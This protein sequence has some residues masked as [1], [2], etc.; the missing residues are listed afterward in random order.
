RQKG[1]CPR[2]CCSF[3]NTAAVTAIDAL[4]QATV[5]FILATLV[6]AP[7]PLVAVRRLRSVRPNPWNLNRL[8]PAEGT[9][10]LCPRSFRLI[11]GPMTHASTHIAIAGYGLLGRLTAWRLLLQGV[12]VSVFEAAT[13]ANSPAAGLS[14]AGMIAPLSEAVV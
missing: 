12:N 7:W 14:A 3:H 13:V 11:R 4:H 6:G 5:G 8:I 10:G 1:Y 2:L 9:S